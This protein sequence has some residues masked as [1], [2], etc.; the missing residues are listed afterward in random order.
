MVL[1]KV[2]VAVM[3]VGRE[4]RGAVTK[5]KMARAPV[6]TTLSSEV[7]VMVSVDWVPLTGDGSGDM[8]PLRL[9]SCGELVDGPSNTLKKS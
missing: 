3:T 1:I 9:N 6:S 5:L 7:K 8:V 4:Q 2:P